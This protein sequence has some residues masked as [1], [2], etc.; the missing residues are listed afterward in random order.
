MAKP[1]IKIDA[2]NRVLE[3]EGEIIET[4]RIFDIYP[5]LIG[6]WKSLFIM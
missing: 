3:L 4:A 2:V 1:R 6:K 5:N